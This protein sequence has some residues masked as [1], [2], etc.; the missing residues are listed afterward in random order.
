MTKNAKHFRELEDF[1]FDIV[2]DFELVPLGTVCFYLAFQIL[3]S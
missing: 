1:N 2:P 3:A